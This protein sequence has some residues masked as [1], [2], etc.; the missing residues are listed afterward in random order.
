MKR[1][2]ALL[3]VLILLLLPSTASAE[4]ILSVQITIAEN[5]VDFPFQSGMRVEIP[6]NIT[7][8]GKSPDSYTVD[9]DRGYL[10][11]LAW[12]TVES[13]D[14]LLPGQSVQGSVVLAFKQGQKPPQKDIDGY[15][16]IK[17]SSS[18]NPAVSDT[19]KIHVRVLVPKLSIDSFQI[20][21][22]KIKEGESIRA[23]VVISNPS[24]VNATGCVMYVLVNSRAWKNFQIRE[25]ASNASVTEVFSVK[26]SSEGPLSIRIILN[27]MGVNITEA[28]RSVFVEGVE[29]NS[30]LYTAIGVLAL[31]AFGVVIVVWRL[32]HG[33]G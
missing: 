11:V 6:F 10:P 9:V 12:S 18:L 8:T 7:N 2:V 30:W 27:Y 15:V 22:S 17:V 23:T 5:D 31:V 26:G 20:S 13:T 25:I 3:S 4:V 33:K 29:D 24:S 1:I 14:V 16:S 32:R 19:E 28:E 21:R